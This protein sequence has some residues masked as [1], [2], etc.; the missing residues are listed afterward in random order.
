MLLLLFTA[1]T[2]KFSMYVFPIKLYLHSKQFTTVLTITTVDIIKTTYK[3]NQFYKFI[4]KHY[5]RYFQIMHTKLITFPPLTE[6]TNNC[7]ITSNHILV[8]VPDATPLVS[9]KQAPG[10]SIQHHQ[11]H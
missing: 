10:T 5:A 2:T 8:V 9:C 6:T 4:C 1:N 11:Q 7:K 3:F